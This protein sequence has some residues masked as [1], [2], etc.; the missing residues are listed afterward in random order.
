MG[1]IHY[2]FIAYLGCGGPQ[3]DAA[4]GPERNRSELRAGGVTWIAGAG[5][6]MGRMHVQRALQL[7]NGPRA[8]V[9]TNRGAARL[10]DLAA[11]LRPPG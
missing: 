5:G 7:A 6:P 4:F 9:A 11:H 1:R 3:I 10:A 8:V 2:E